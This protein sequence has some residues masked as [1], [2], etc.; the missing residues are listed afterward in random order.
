MYDPCHDAQKHPR[1]MGNPAE[2]VSHS[3]TS[4][5]P[6]GTRAT[7]PDT[8]IG[9]DDDVVSGFSPHGTGGSLDHQAASVVADVPSREHEKVILELSGLRETLGK[10]QNAL[11]SRQEFKSSLHPGV[12]D[13][14][15]ESHPYGGSA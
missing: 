13:S 7:S 4:S 11:D 15:V 12:T 14:G 3:P 2:G 5:P 10:T 8:D 9:H 6:P 1:R